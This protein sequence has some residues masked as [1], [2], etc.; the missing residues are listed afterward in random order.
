MV[1]D[2]NYLWFMRDRCAC[3]LRVRSVADAV[4]L[5]RPAACSDRSATGDLE[6][7]QRQVLP[8]V[9]RELMAARKIVDEVAAMRSKVVAMEVADPPE[10]W[11]CAGFH[12]EPDGSCQVGSITFNLTAGSGAWEDQQR[13]VLSLT[14]ETDSTAAVV[15]SST[16]INGLKW[17]VAPQ[18]SAKSQTVEHPNG[19]VGIQKVEHNPVETWDTLVQLVHTVLPPPRQVFAHKN[20]SGNAQHVALW[21]MDGQEVFEM[22]DGMGHAVMQRGDPVQDEIGMLFFV[23]KDSNAASAHLGGNASEPQGDRRQ[24]G[25]KTKALGISVRVM[26]FMEPLTELA[27]L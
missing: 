10:A 11:R 15:G 5:R 16:E 1:S 13:G 21:K 26:V 22:A 14:V 9:G 23:T 25:I 3:S 8:R 6:L 27:S 24:F 12:V 4:P 19:V 7:S 2:P 17:I 20:P 18:G